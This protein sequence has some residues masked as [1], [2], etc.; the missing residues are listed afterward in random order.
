MSQGPLPV[1]WAADV[2][3][4]AACGARRCGSEMTHYNHIGRPEDRRR[5]AAAASTTG[6]KLADE[7]DQYGLPIPR[8]TFSY[9][10]NDRRL[11][12][13]SHGFMRAVLRR[14]ARKRVWDEVDDTAT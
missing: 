4:S 14:P 2:G 11:I 7:T 8:V 3:P 6:S 12:D 10:D 9:S 13:H 1:G 5:D